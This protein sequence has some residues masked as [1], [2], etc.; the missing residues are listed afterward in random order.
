MA[1]KLSQICR[2][3]ARDILVLNCG[4]SSIKFS[5]VDPQSGRS[6][7]KGQVSHLGDP[8]VNIQYDIDGDEGQ[9]N[10]SL[11]TCSYQ[12][13]FYQVGQIC[14]LKPFR[15]IGHR[16]VH[17]GDLYKT[18]ILITDQ[19][20]QN[21]EGLSDFAPLHNPLSAQCITHMTKH[22]PS[23][24][25]VGVFDTAFHQTIPDYVY[26]YAVPQA[27]YETHQ[28][29]KYGF[30]GISHQFVAQEAATRL[31]RPLRDLKVVSAH[32]GN[33]CSVAAIKEGLC[34]DTSMGI[35]PLAGLVMGTRSG[36][37]DPAVLGIMAKKTNLSLGQILEVLNTESGLKGVCG[38]QDARELER[39]YTRGN[40]FARLAWE[41]FAYR[42]AKYVASYVVPLGG[43]DVLIFTGGIGEK[44]SLIR[45]KTIGW[46]HG[47]GFDLDL[48][49]N[50]THGSSSNGLISAGMH[51]PIITVIPTQEALM[52][53]RETQR[54][55]D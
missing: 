7:L 47:L 34:V 29:R 10:L 1:F 31:N 5:T 16:V 45:T 18:S 23:I 37:I 22:F 12:E 21:I 54:L 44:S 32:L 20:I 17:G 27:W 38:Y 42:L 40:R 26:R 28:I 6:V 25:Q 48:D 9:K 36:D 11:E 52:I 15:A 30:H 24:R 14:A 4:S 51:H 46:L 3:P 8:T 49:R 43:I 53:A 35:T 55:T 2:H 19:V 41:M 39:A 13:I 50:E 33:G